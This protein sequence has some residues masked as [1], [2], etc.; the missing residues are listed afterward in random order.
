VIEIWAVI[1]EYAVWHI[2]VSAFDRA[3]LVEEVSL[4]QP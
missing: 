2:E 4:A 1:K 3:P